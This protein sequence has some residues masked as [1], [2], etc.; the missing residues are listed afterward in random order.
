MTLIFSSDG[1]GAPVSIALSKSASQRPAWVRHH[2]HAG[3][4]VTS[5][6]DLILDLKDFTDSGPFLASHALDRWGKNVDFELGG[7]DQD[8]GLLMLN[9]TT[10]FQFL[11]EITHDHPLMPSVRASLRGDEPLERIYIRVQK[12]HVMRVL[13]EVADGPFKSET[14]L[15]H[16]LERRRSGSR[17][18]LSAPAAGPPA[19]ERAC[20]T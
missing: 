8:R 17:S 6:G 20:S 13:T 9:M 4:R 5:D 3:D 18:P 19:S 14:E 7:V 12:E 10:L 2:G 11:E 15:L 16:A 1:F